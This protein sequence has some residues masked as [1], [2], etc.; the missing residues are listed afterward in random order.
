[1]AAPCWL[2]LFSSTC[3]M[4]ECG[5]GGYRWSQ[6]PVSTIMSVGLRDEGGEGQRRSGSCEDEPDLGAA[7]GVEPWT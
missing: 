7:S 4:V 6:D 1:M 2:E 3:I 5:G